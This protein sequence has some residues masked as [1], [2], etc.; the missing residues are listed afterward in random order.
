MMK[1]VFGGRLAGCL[2]FDESVALIKDLSSLK[3]SAVAMAIS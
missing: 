1:P 3:K 2:N